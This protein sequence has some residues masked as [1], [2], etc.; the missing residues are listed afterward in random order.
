MPLAISRSHEWIRQFLD[1]YMN[2]SFRL[3][4][5]STSKLPSD[6]KQQGRNMGY[7]IVSLAKN[8]DIFP[9]LM[10]NNDQT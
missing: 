7:T 1:Q 6:W 4:T 5:T 8:Y 9:T 3:G 10:V 2:W